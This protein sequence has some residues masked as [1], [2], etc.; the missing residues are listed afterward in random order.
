MKKFFLGLLCIG[1]FSVSNISA[2]EQ[3]TFT[4]DEALSILNQIVKRLVHDSKA[5]KKE[6]ASLKEMLAKEEESRA[7]LADLSNRI[8]VLESMT[9]ASKEGTAKLEPSKIKVDN[10][11][12]EYINE[13]NWVITPYRKQRNIFF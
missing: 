4:Q 9:A 8:G 3:V 11:I 5:S 12:L 2:N 1:V 6:I 10:E 13:K 7:T